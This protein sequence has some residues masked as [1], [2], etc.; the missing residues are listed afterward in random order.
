MLEF[1]GTALVL[2]ISFVLFVVLESFIFYF[3]MRKT[4]DERADYIA[5]NEK[6]A[7]KN[8]LEAQ[9]L[10]E[11]KD[12]KIN[13]ANLESAQILN[14]VSMETQA[15][16]DNAIKEAKMNSNNKLE[17]IKKNLDEEQVVAQNALRGEIASYASTIISKIL[18]KDIA[19]VNVNDEILDKAMR[20]E[21]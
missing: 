8:N 14:N 15:E 11:E 4:L 17:E 2:A 20:G 1:N 7:D 10:I 16:F 6:E 5:G 9:K 18:K 13:Q 19:M 12:V 3:P 21:L